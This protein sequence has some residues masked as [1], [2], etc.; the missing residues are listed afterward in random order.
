MAINLLVSGKSH[1][2]PD[3]LYF[4]RESGVLALE[5]FDVDKQDKVLN[6][7]ISLSLVTAS[8]RDEIEVALR[9]EDRQE[10]YTTIRVDDYLRYQLETVGGATPEAFRFVFKLLS[11]GAA[12]V[13][14]STIPEECATR[15]VWEVPRI[16]YG[17]IYKLFS[18][19][20]TLIAMEDGAS[21][22]KRG[23]AMMW[24]ELDKHTQFISDT[25]RSL[26][27]DI[28]SLAQYRI[29]P[30]GRSMADLDAQLG[31]L[32][33]HNA[34][35]S[36]PVAYHELEAALDDFKLIRHV[37]QVYRGRSNADCVLSLEDLGSSTLYYPW[38]H[39]PFINR[40]IAADKFTAEN[41]ANIYVALDAEAP[42]QTQTLKVLVKWTT[43]YHEGGT[44]DYRHWEFYVSR[45][46]GTKPL[47]TYE[48]DTF[49]SYCEE[50]RAIFDPL[51]AFLSKAL[52]RPAAQLNIF[53]SLMGV[54]SSEQTRRDIFVLPRNPDKEE[55]F[56]LKV[57]F[58]RP[59]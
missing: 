8:S 57:N 54:P 13:K 36:S 26:S 44:F 51:K 18:D 37:S 32:A 11:G 46:N 9:T 15:Y 23:D 5:E 49:S 59:F 34:L 12:F 50:Q 45:V 17:D 42:Q 55:S 1:L 21:A 22:L 48:R 33:L 3:Y 6:R 39:A 2:C 20:R 47:F 27:L 4:D 25:P 35:R 31:Q 14:A 53:M 43:K 30:T 56:Y 19:G 29:E 16:R 52:K 7:F 40:S 58:H 28:C 41:Y 24:R 10:V 38:S